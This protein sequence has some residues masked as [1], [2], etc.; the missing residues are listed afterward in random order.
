MLYL[1]LNIS[2]EFFLWRC[3]PTRVMA[4][5]FLMFLDHTQRRTTVGTTPLDEWSARHRDLYLATHNTH[6]RQTSMLLEGIL[7]HDLSRRAAADLLLRSRGHSDWHLYLIMAIKPWWDGW[8]CCT[9]GREVHV[10]FG[11]EWLKKRAVGR[12]G[13]RFDDNIKIELK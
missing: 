11:L 13:H 7:T 2:K 5:S 3:A 6:N 1:Y 9:R 12:N 4:S 10:G 8:T